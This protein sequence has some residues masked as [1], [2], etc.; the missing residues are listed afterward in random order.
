[1]S[2]VPDSLKV[3]GHSIMLA[4]PLYGLVNAGRLWVGKFMGVLTSAGYKQSSVEPTLF[5]AWNDEKLG[6]GI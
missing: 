1:M 5:Y 3:P 2:Y 4:R 6:T